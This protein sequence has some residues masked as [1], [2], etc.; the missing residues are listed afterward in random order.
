MRAW[1][2]GWEGQGAG[3]EETVEPERESK[4]G[5]EE[6]SQLAVFWEQV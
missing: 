6:K 1:G 2:K 5:R 3:G 4:G